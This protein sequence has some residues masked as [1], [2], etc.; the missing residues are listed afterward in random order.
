ML[1]C[2]RGRARGGWGAYRRGWGSVRGSPSGLASPRDVVAREIWAMMKRTSSPCAYLD[3]THRPAEWLKER[4]PA[5]H[6]R[7]LAEGIDMAREPIPVVPAAHYACGGVRT[8]LS[9]R[10]SLRGLWVAGEVASTGLHGS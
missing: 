8:D 4:F 10:R 6:A 9:G 3:I 2:L 1:P 7:C 5:I